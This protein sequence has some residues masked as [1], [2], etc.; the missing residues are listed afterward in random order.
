MWG[1]RRGSR[2]KWYW[3]FPGNC[4]FCATLIQQKLFTGET[5]FHLEMLLWCCW[6]DSCA[7]SSS[8]GFSAWT[9][10]LSFHLTLKSTIIG[11][12]LRA[13][14]KKKN[15]LF[16]IWTVIWSEPSAQTSNIQVIINEST[17]LMCYDIG[18][19]YSNGLAQISLQWLWCVAVLRISQVGAASCMGMEMGKI[20]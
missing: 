3:L 7:F 18:S 5:S 4:E 19:C 6:V 12:F 15:Y 8:P 2:R 9:S 17:L 20:P 14:M 16:F 11:V 1:E 13:L 10:F